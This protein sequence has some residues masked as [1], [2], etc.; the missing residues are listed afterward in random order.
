MKRSLFT[1]G[2][3]RMK[4]K[5][6]LVLG[7]AFVCSSLLLSSN[8]FA[9][10]SSDEG[11]VCCSPSEAR[12]PSEVQAA[13]P[14]LTPQEEPA[15]ASTLRNLSEEIERRGIEASL[16]TSFHSL[17]LKYDS[18][19]DQMIELN[20]AFNLMDRKVRALLAQYQT[21]DQIVAVSQP[22]RNAIARQIREAKNALEMLERTLQ[23][24][25]RYSVE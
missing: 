11:E 8:T 5:V 10:V 20:E 9:M 4:K 12:T 2:R 1:G 7:A 3:K 17:L 18:T 25:Y 14:Q 21:A 15:L 16:L 19:R 23:V 22:E 24:A 13:E 6:A